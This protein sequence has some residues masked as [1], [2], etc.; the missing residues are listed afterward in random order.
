MIVGVSLI[1][2]S[3]DRSFMSPKQDLDQTRADLEQNPARPFQTILVRTGDPRLEVMHSGATKAAAIAQLAKTVIQCSMDQIMAFGD[4]A[5]D[6]EMLSECGMGVAMG[7]ADENVKAVGKFVAPTNGEDGL[8]RVLRA[9][10][11]IDP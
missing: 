11:G 10:F 9:V 7:N 1:L 8:A 6:I 2:V 4:G 5:N 3:T